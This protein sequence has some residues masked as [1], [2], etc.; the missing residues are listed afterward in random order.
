MFLYLIATVALL[1]LVVI[2]ISGIE[3]CRFIESQVAC[4]KLSKAL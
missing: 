3:L 4:F 1:L 2:L